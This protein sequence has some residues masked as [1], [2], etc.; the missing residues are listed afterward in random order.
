MKPIHLYNTL[1][2]YFGPQ[3]W[4]PARTEF[5]VSVGAI[6]TQQTTWKNV[7]KAIKELRKRKLLS[8]QTL[9]PTPIHQIAV[10]IYPTGYYRQKAKRLKSLAI[11]FPRIQ[12]HKKKRAIELRSE[13]LELNGIGKETADSI[14]LYAFKKPILPIDAYTLRITRRVYGVE[15]DYEQIRTFYESQLPRNTQLLNE[16]HALLV[17]LA[18]NYCKSKKPLCSD[19]PVKRCGFHKGPYPTNKVV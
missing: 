10:L 18:K 14:L 3:G 15:G 13:L 9:A 12:K 17:E 2:S 19:C 7:E 11:N 4:W 6:L 16:F 1:L 8:P 5:E